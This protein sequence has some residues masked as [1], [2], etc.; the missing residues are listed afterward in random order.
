MEYRQILFQDSQLLIFLQIS[1]HVMGQAVSWWPVTTEDWIQSHPSSC[2]ICGV[3]SGNGTDFSSRTSVLPV[4]IIPP[5]L[6]LTD[7]SLILTIWRR[8]Y[9]F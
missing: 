7:V 5:M 1:G 6:H 3:Q 9:F 4:S 2:W 8:N